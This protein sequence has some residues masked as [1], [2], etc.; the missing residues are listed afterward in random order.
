MRKLDIRQPYQGMK[1][2]QLVFMFG[3]IH[4]TKMHVY[5]IYNKSNL[6]KL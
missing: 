2:F 5:A 6:H 3:I 4:A 1:V